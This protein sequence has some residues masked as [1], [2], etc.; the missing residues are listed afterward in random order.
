MPFHYL[1][2]LG[3]CVNGPS[4]VLYWNGLYVYV[5]N[6]FLR[7]GRLDKGEVSLCDV[8]WF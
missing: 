1:V 4:I 6:Y 3:A 8:V 2:G 7:S 5:I